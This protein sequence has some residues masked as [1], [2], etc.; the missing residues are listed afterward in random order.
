MNNFDNGKKH[1]M[2]HNADNSKN[3]NNNKTSVSILRHSIEKNLKV[4]S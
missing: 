2:L 4:F 3:N 1:K